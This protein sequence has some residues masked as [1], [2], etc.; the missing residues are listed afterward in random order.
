MTLRNFFLAALSGLLL[1]AGFPPFGFHVLSWVSLIPLLFAL[2]FQ[3]VGKGF[4]LG[5]FTGLVFFA[6]TVHWVTNSVH[7]Y[8]GI[9]VVTASLITLLLC[10]FLACFIAGFGAGMVRLRQRHPSLLFLS[11]PPLWTGIELA[12]TYL[13][14]GFPWAL[15]GYSQ[16]RVLP[17][18]QFAD[19]TGV[20]GVSF[21]I[22][23]VN[24][25]LYL[26]LQDRR[27][28][29]ALVVAL[30]LTA[31]VLAYGSMK[32]GEP[33]G[34][35]GITL[36]VVQGNIDQDRKWDPAYQAD[37]IETYERLTR[38]ALKRRPDLVIWPETATPF[39]FGGSGNNSV[40][41]NDLERFVRSTGTPLLTGSPTYRVRPG[42][43]VELRNSAVLLERGGNIAATYHKRHLVPF[44]E[45][46]PF[47]SVLF[48]VE[49]LVDA[50]GDFEAGTEYTVMRAGSGAASH[51]TAFSTVICYEIIFPDLVRRFVGNG[52][53]VIVTI[54]NDAWFGRT[55]APSQ[56]FSMAVLRAVE[57]RVPVARAANTGISGFIDAKGR[58][59]ETS[60][61]F[62]EDV[63]T[64]VLTPGNGKTFYTMHGDV[65]AY[66]CAVFSLLLMAG[67]GRAKPSGNGPEADRTLKGRPDAVRT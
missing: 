63:L 66:A 26:M 52:A 59:L 30:A 37:V 20:Y 11:A 42:G 51:E 10:A 40:L 55:A 43:I 49:K 9:P 13:F 58:I 22:V 65:F 24:V 17:V 16:Y 7:Y 6:A 36:S 27:Q 45:Y 53:S 19:I 4:V 35:G 67:W 38:E 41:T 2:R 34:G 14:S 48:F 60:G 33:A 57:N 1:A 28:F 8:G 23:L 47:K 61:I 50:V 18:I 54:T 12:R 39:Y 46:V 15:L 44:G 32:L 56:H 21:L 64:R 31:G 62:T 3:S 25:S 29:P 5:G